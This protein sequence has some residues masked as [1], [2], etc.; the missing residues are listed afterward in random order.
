MPYLYLYIYEA[1][2]Y[3]TLIAQKHRS[4]VNLNAAMLHD[5]SRDND[6]DI[7]LMYTAYGG[8]FNLRR[9]KANTKVKVATLREL[10]GLRCHYY[11][12]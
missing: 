7:Q 11:V 8:V 3:T 12:E 10:L 5:D 9:L 2:I 4:F 1:P 6:D